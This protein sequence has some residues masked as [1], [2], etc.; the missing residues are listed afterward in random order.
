MLSALP[1]GW[2]GEI[3]DEELVASPRPTAA[4]TRA[5]FMLGV[6]L[7]E[8]LDKRRGGSGRWCFLR[9][10]EL[11]LGHDML[12]PDM[13]GWRRE[14]VDVPFEPDVPFLTLVPDWV[15]RGA[16]GPPPPRWTARASCRSTRAR[17]CRTC[18]WWTPPRARWRCT[19]ASSGAGC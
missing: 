15:L 13:A 8:Q 5:A 7:G 1:S 11:H 16:D 6:E 4:Q 19:S 18:G 14:R 10:P 12:V 2:V 17:A 9:A 3:L